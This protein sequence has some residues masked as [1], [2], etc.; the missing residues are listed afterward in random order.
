[1]SGS[2]TSYGHLRSGRARAAMRGVFWSAVSGFAPAA[3]SGQALIQRQEVRGAHLDSV[4]WLCVGVSLA[5]YAGLVL[6]APS[7]ARLLGEA[8]IAVLLPVLG[9]R[10]IFDLAAVVPNALLTRSMSF[11]KMAW[12]TTIASLVAAFILFGI[13]TLA[14]QIMVEWLPGLW[15]NL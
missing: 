12:R 3:V 4:F 5:I 15:G 13:D 1:M 2:D 6:A 14:Y 7:L 8:G 11:D 10:V 9:T